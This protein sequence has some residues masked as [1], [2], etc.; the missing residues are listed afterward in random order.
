MLSNQVSNF[1]H[2]QPWTLVDNGG[3][4]GP[5]WTR[6]CP[7]QRPVDWLRDEETSQQVGP[8][9]ARNGQ[10]TFGCTGYKSAGKPHPGRRTAIGS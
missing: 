3:H 8:V 5:G 2:D 6:D 1:H 9:C 7:A 10:D 4:S